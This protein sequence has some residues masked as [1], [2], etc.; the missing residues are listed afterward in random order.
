ME[1]VATQYA[2]G[3]SM[4]AADRDII[5]EP[6][7]QKEKHSPAALELWLDRNIPIVKLSTAAATTA[8]T[9]T[10]KKITRFFSRKRP[11]D[12]PGETLPHPRDLSSSEAPGPV[13]TT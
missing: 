5:A 10:Y 8:I 7:L 1:Q 6:I 4:L 3:P 9:K 2:Q 13:C 11:P 12:P